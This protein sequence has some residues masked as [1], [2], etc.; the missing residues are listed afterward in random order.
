MFDRLVTRDYDFNYRPGLAESWDVSEDGL[1]WTFHLL[2]GV[3]FHNGEP[4]TA[5]DVKWTF[6]T[7]LDP[8]TASP[9][10]GDLGAIAEI[11]RN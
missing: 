8:E 4:L 1:T 6:E 11:N 10:A 7:I 2:E 3:T 5:T 9:F